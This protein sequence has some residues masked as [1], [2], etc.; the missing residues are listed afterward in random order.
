MGAAYDFGRGV[1]DAVLDRLTNGSG[2]NSGLRFSFDQKG[3]EE[4]TGPVAK[5]YEVKLR[6]LTFPSGDGPEGGELERDTLRMKLLSK[7][8]NGPLRAEIMWPSNQEKLLDCVKQEVQKE[9][10]DRAE[11]VADAKCEVSVKNYLSVMDQKGELHVSL[12]DGIAVC[13][14]SK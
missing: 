2:S 12:I 4:G 6:G 14:E 11:P 7:T 13:H 9:V 8:Q 3:K 10:D 5:S 1:G